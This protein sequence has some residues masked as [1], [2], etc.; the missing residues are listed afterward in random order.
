MIEGCMVNP[1]QGVFIEFGLP[2]ELKMQ[3]IDL[4]LNI[5]EGMMTFPELHPNVEISQLGISC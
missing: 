4:S 5:E 3:I 2:R 1:T